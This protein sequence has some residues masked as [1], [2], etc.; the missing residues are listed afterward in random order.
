MWEFLETMSRPKSKS[1]NSD[2]WTGELNLPRQRKK[3]R[4]R[5]SATR[6]L[7]DPD[8]RNEDNDDTQDQS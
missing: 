8:E 6:R 5:K 3:S 7:Q 4:R 1:T 2:D